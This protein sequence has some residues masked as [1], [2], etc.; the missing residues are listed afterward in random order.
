MLLDA[1][2]SRV[3]VVAFHVTVVFWYGTTYSVFMFIYQIRE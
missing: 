1:C 3:P 2:L